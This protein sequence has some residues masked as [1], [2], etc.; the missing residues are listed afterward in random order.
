[1]TLYQEEASTREKLTSVRMRGDDEPI[2]LA[3][4]HKEVKVMLTG[5]ERSHRMG[6][7]RGA[8]APGA[9]GVLA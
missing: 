6:N 2:R 5:A 7:A 1:V 3:D 4:V 8:D 9:F